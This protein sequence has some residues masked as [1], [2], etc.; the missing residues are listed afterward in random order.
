[1]PVRSLRSSILRWPDRSDVDSAVRAWA[2]EQARIRPGL[3][4]PGYFGS[5]ATGNWGVGSDL[6][7]VAVVASCA[8]PFGERALE[9]DLT[10]LPVPAEILIYTTAEWARVLQ[11]QDRFA[12][13]MSKEVVWVNETPD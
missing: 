2:R 3:V 1:M 10:K 9:W 8:R 13:V 6:D 12:R 5:Y 11:K 7:S 4:R